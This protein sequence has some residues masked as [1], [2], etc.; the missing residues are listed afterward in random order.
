M[1]SQVGEIR[2]QVDALHDRQAE[3]GEI[4]RVTAAVRLDERSAPPRRAGPEADPRRG[5]SDPPETSSMPAVESVHPVAELRPPDQPAGGSFYREGYS[6]YHRGEYERSEQALRA[7]LRVEPDSPYADNAEYWIGE[8]YYARGRYREAIEQFQSVLR[9]YPDG[10]KRAHALYKVAL[11]HEK[12][13]ERQEM[14]V[15]LR[16][17]IRSYPESD[18]ADQARSR[19]EGT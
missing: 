16:S 5:G 6:L 17:L 14:R 10:N 9:R 2:R 18:V 13:G 15:S 7:F 8:C 3:N 11:A 12:L 4:I 1:Q 19:L